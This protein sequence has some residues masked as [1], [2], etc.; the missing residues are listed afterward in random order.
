MI[1][2]MDLPAAR[3]QLDAAAGVA[4]S[5]TGTD[6]STE[7]VSQDAQLQ[8]RRRPVLTLDNGRYYVTDSLD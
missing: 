6:V 5:D 2:A 1:N 8:G 4:S 3:A 7:L